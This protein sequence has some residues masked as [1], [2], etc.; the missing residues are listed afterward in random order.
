[1]LRPAPWGA[2]LC[3]ERSHWL[4]HPGLALTMRSLGPP[5]PPFG[6]RCLH[7]SPEALL[8]A[9]WGHGFV[10]E[11]LMRVMERALL[12]W[13]QTQVVIT[14]APSRVRT[15]F[16]VGAQGVRV[17]GT[18]VTLGPPTAGL[19]QLC[20]PLPPGGAVR[21]GAGGVQKPPVP[22]HPAGAVV[23]QNPP[24]LSCAAGP[25]T[26]RP[27]ASRE[28]RGGRCLL[29]P[30]FRP[31]G[32][33]CVCGHL[34]WQSVCSPPKR[35]CS[36]AEL[37]TAEEAA[38]SGAALLSDHVILSLGMCVLGALPLSLSPGDFVRQVPGAGWA[39][40]PHERWEQGPCVRQA[41]KTVPMRFVACW[42]HPQARGRALGL[43]VESRWGAACTLALAHARSPSLPLSLPTLGPLGDRD[44]QNSPCLRTSTS[45][46]SRATCRGPRGTQA[47]LW[48]SWTRTR[49]RSL[50]C[51]WGRA[52]WSSATRVS[53]TGSCAPARVPLR[54]SHFL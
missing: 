38:E 12:V 26:V 34:H 52:A 37:P 23:L 53:F 7:R 17:S 9:P 41:Q 14:I 2:P 35:A 28:S 39:G 44:G 16:L 42:P 51:S 6:A 15:H 32:A 18:G 24:Q 20:E 3:Q 40:C 21:R 22:P 29:E 13:Q 11:I 10:V 47:C 48:L 50:R 19:A 36:S 49:R 43:T 46:S 33:L 4:L 30:P 27:L 1:M 8:P 54:G 45:C 5:L 25:P 31:F